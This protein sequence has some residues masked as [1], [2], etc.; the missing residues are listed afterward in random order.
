[1]VNIPGCCQAEWVDDRVYE[2]LKKGSYDITVISAAHCFKYPKEI[3]HYRIPSVLPFEAFSE[4]NEIK[5]M[6][7]DIEDRPVLVNYLKFMTLIYKAFNL[8]N[9]KIFKGEGRWFWFFPSSLILI[10]LILRNK[11]DLIYSTG[12]PA[13]AHFTNVL[14][15]RLFKINNVIELQ[16]P[17]S[18]EDIGRNKFSK[19]ALSTA[20]KILIKNSKKI[21]YAT[22]S[23]MMNAKNTYPEY[24]SKIYFIY[25]GAK[26]NKFIKKNKNKKIVFSYIGSLYQTRNLDVFLEALDKLDSDYNYDYELNLYGWIADDIKKRILSKNNK[27]IKFFGMVSREVAHIKA[28]NSDVLILVQHTDNRSSLTIPFKIYDYLNTN[29]LILGLTYKNPEIDS[30]LFDHG[31]ISCSAVSIEEV[32]QK[33]K[34]IMSDLKGL[35]KKIKTSSLNPKNALIEME[36]IILL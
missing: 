25:P 13:S 19:K 34:L 5:N 15:S 2:M 1:M 36:K 28:Q 10:N 18:G 32:S 27:K 35:K 26:A 21:L 30:I 11:Y 22:K 7:I 33:I 20:E 12:G 23:A 16:D 31:H 3:K 24:E 17:L 9:I 29:N 6:N 8:L 4:Y 14:I